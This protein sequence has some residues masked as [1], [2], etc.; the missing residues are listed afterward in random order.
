M[1]IKLE[2]TFKTVEVYETVEF[3]PQDYPELEGMS[4]EEIINY[5]NEN[6]GEFTINGTDEVLIDHFLFDKDLQYDETMDHE[7]VISIVND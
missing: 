5:L 2:R 1:K 4:N 7:D 6:I 3:N